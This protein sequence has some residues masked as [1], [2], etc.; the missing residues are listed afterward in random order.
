MCCFHRTNDSNT[1]R[2]GFTT[3]VRSFCQCSG[4]NPTKYWLTNNKSFFVFFSKK[5]SSM[6][7]ESNTLSSFP[8]VLKI[9]LAK[10]RFFMRSSWE[11]SMTF[12]GNV[13]T[14]LAMMWGSTSIWSSIRVGTTPSVHRI[15]LVK[16][17]WLVKVLIFP[18]QKAVDFDWTE[19]LLRN[20]I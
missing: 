4:H 19:D 16:K 12:H 10:G 13:F 8:V 1:G 18:S 6:T 11:M 2:C 15:L 7:S 5:L 3:F 14:F 20:W 9:R 17:D